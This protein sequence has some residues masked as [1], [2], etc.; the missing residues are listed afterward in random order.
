M[1]NTSVRWPLQALGGGLQCCSSGCFFLASISFS[2]FTGPLVLSP[3]FKQLPSPSATCMSVIAARC[4]FCPRKSRVPSYYFK[5]WG[6]RW[7]VC[8]LRGSASRPASNR[9]DIAVARN[10]CIEKE[11]RSPS[12]LIASFSQTCRIYLAKFCSPKFGFLKNE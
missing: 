11:S 6:W 10:L 5:N 2:S 9:F 1:V 8:M 12:T 4:S 3:A 7:P